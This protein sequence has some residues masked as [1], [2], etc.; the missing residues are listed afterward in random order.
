MSGPPRIPY[1][2]LGLLPI[3]GDRRE[4][5]SSAKGTVGEDQRRARLV[6]GGS[7]RV[8][9]RTI[10]AISSILLLLVA[11]AATPSSEPWKQL[12][13]TVEAGTRER[14]AKHGRWDRKG[15]ICT[16]KEAAHLQLVD[17]PRHGT[18]AFGREGRRPR[19]CDRKLVHAVVYYTAARDYVGSDA[20]SYLRIDPESGEQRLVTVAVLVE[21]PATPLPGTPPPGGAK[22][23][24]AA[25]M[26]ASGRAAWSCPA[27]CPLF[28]VVFTGDVL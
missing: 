13:A 15:K 27:P 26:G 2:P 28:Q 9:L 3:A 25:P 21:R 23:R 11:R 22:P 17:K 16:P 12:K 6:T 18:V 10:A 4:P 7:R 19:H 20:F 24:A 5:G 1:A 8:S 14:V